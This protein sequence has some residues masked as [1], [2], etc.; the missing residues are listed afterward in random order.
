MGRLHQ[1][2]RVVQPAL[3]QQ[4]CRARADM[5]TLGPR[6]TARQSAK[7]ATHDSILFPPLGPGEQFIPI[8]DGLT[9]GGSRGLQRSLEMLD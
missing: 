1:L 6:R 4:P 3:R 5:A 9:T 2:H 7:T 8:G